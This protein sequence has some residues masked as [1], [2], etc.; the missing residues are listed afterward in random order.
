MLLL[1]SVIMILACPRA[2]G[3]FQAKLGNFF[4]RAASARNQAS[5]ID[6]AEASKREIVKNVVNIRAGL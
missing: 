6:D 1:F 3:N 2:Q 4:G 5:S